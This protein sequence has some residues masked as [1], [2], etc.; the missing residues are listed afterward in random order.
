VRTEQVERNPMSDRESL[1]LPAFPYNR[2]RK[3]G[4]QSTLFRRTRVSE[5]FSESTNGVSIF[6][7]R[8]VPKDASVREL[9]VRVR[10][11]SGDCSVPWSMSATA[12]LNA[13]G[14]ETS[15]CYLHPSGLDWTQGRRLGSSSG[16][17]ECEVRTVTIE[18][19]SRN[20]VW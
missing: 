12:V 14:R 10:S 11:N 16:V 3:R 8:V 7:V 5:E 9:F 13:L 18:N 19:W 2:T 4:R 6:R 17:L 1:L 15:A 20:A